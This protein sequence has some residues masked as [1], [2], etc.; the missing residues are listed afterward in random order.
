MSET[1]NLDRAVARNIKSR[2]STDFVLNINLLNTDGS[3]LD[4]TNFEFE[5]QVLN[6]GI[7]LF[8]LAAG[9]GLTVN[10]NEIQLRIDDASYT[11]AAGNYYYQ[12]KVTNATGIVQ[13]WLNGRFF[14]FENSVSN[15]AS[16][17]ELI[18]LT[19]PA[20]TSNINLTITN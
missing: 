16:V 1:I 20:S 8:T 5:F 17:S 2:R 3:A 10:A 11:F 13:Y 7:S 12:F 4:T 14:I 6:N 9:S 19:I 15:A 18:N